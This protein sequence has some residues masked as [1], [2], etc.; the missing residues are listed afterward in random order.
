MRLIDRLDEQ[1]IELIPEGHFKDGKVCLPLSIRI[2]LRVWDIF[3][4]IR[5]RVFIRGK[6]ALF[7]CEE[8]YGG[9]AFLPEDAMEWWC[10]R[11]GAEG[12]NHVVYSRRMFYGDNKL[13]DF[14]DALRGR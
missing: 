10:R 11:C 1:I 2:I 6:C 12:I 13:E 5:Y 9:S 14:I 3:M 4:T 7:G 8:S